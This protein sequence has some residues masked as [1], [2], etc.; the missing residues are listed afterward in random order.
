[1]I[2]KIIFIALIIGSILIGII[3]PRYYLLGMLLMFV[4]FIGLLYNFIV[5]KI[6]LKK[7]IKEIKNSISSIIDN[8]E[9]EVMLK[10]RDINI[11][12]DLRTEIYELSRILMDDIDFLRHNILNSIDIPVYISSS[13][14]IFKNKAM[15]KLCVE[16]GKEPADLDN[17]L[18]SEGILYRKIV[19][20]EDLF[21]FLPIAEIHSTE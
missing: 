15:K 6:R 11:L 17:E 9:P 12:N 21:Y 14:R 5:F 20:R 19:I 3:L 8:A 2:K 7:E 16:I 1:M 4:G 18:E 13:G 10:Q